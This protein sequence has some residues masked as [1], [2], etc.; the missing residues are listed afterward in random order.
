MIICFV[1]AAAS[2]ASIDLPW[3]PFRDRSHLRWIIFYL[4]IDK[5]TTVAHPKLIDISITVLAR[6]DNIDIVFF[7]AT[8]NTTGA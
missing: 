4:F 2:A 1:S 6:A 8:C 7:N 5:Q 3:S